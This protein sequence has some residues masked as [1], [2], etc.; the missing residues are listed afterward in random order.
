MSKKLIL[1]LVAVFFLCKFSFA[2]AEVVI[3]EVQLSPT[4]GRFVELYNNGS[5]A[6][7]LTNWYI[8]R[9][10]ATGSD[11]G[12]LVS[13]TYFENKIINAGAYFLIS[14]SA[15]DKADIVLDSLTLT[16]SNTIQLKN[17]DQAVVDKVGWGSG[18]SSVAD[19]PPDGQSIQRTDSGSWVSATPTP[20]AA[21]ETVSSPPP[22]VSTTDDQS[23]GDD[24]DSSDSVSSA[25]SSNG[26]ASS[27]TKTA[28]ITQK[29]KVQIT[30]NL[31]AYVGIPFTLEGNV[32]G[33]E[34]E[35]LVYGKYFWNFGDGD[36][37][38]A[39]V[40]SNEKIM[41]TYFY[42]GDY[43]VLLEYY[44]NYL[45]DTP[46]AT[47]KVT[48]KVV[49]PE[50]SISSVGDEKDFFIEL[51]NNGGDNVDI[52]N[53]F[54]VSDNKSFTFPRNTIL[55]PNKTMTISSQI[56]HFSIG[57]KNTLKLLNSQHA[58]AFDYTT[59]P[60]PRLPIGG[61]ASPKEREQSMGTV[62]LSLPPSGRVGG[63]GEPVPAL[64]NLATSVVSSDV[65]KNE[66]ANN[67]QGSVL[68]VIIFIISIAFIGA[69]AYAV[70]FIRR[71]R[72]VP[73]VGSDFEILDE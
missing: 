36:S 71:K 25:A 73:Q 2:R 63:V 44:S 6:V 64:K 55:E 7:D 39:P 58:V 45:A 72:V 19:N 35:R 38:E 9:K 57:D 13:K 69:S 61:Q 70:Y 49:A 62:S 54:L 51:K 16:E 65:V 27:K 3:N 24:G 17:G 5:S 47:E 4:E 31:L 32:F 43:T 8:Q 10:T 59:P 18:E 14:K 42:P 28:V 41:H 37:R 46:D 53:W 21:N 68:S 56:T 22:S 12:S 15:M 11:F 20:G 33:T 66:E 40:T 48:I 29:T 60:Q 67:P 23:S 50:I 34:G 52:S 1:F 30:A 26:T